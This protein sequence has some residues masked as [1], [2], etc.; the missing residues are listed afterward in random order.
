[1]ALVRSKSEK[2]N[3]GEIYAEKGQLESG[4]KT[5]E[6][7]TVSNAYG[8]L[9]RS[10]GQVVRIDCWAARQAIRPIRYGNHAVT[11]D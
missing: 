9:R 7:L 8:H 11:Q 1:M 5:N 4:S 3:V 2:E 6:C 10:L